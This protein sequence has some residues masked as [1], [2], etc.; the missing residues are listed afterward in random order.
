M[1]NHISPFLGHLKVARLD[2]DML[3]SFYAELGAAAPLLRPPGRAITGRPTR[4]SATTGAARTNA[5]RWPEHGPAHAL[6]P[7][8]RL[9]AGGAM[10]VGVGQPDRAGR[11]AAGAEAEPRAAD[12]GGAARIVNEAWRDP[13]WGAPV[14]GRDDHRSQRGELCAMRWSSVG[15]DQGRET[16]WLRRAI[17]KDARA[18]GRGRPEDPPA[19][20]DRPRPETATTCESTA[21]A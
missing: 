18:A 9:Q 2:A 17:R 8:R 4:T 20:A 1:R 7:L 5:G 10:A 13:A 19:T 6:H 11:A 12:S 15:L 14:V 21:T 16:I 3:D